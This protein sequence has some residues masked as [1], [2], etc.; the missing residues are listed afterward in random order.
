MATPAMTRWRAGFGIPRLLVALAMIWS[1][2]KVPRPALP[3]IYKTAAVPTRMVMIA[4][5]KLKTSLAVMVMAALWV[6]ALPTWLLAVM[7][8]TR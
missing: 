7:A 3:L 6:M 1:V 5:H 2:T 8:M 4:F